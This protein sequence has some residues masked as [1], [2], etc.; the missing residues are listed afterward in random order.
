M[1]AGARQLPILVLRHLPYL[2]LALLVNQPGFLVE[3]L[4]L[5]GDNLPLFINFNGYFDVLRHTGQVLLLE[6]FLHFILEVQ[7]GHLKDPDESFQRLQLVFKIVYNLLVPHQS[8][9]I[10]FNLLVR[11]VHVNV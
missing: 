6:G 11:F 7:V 2:D 4:V 1:L 10:V 8:V 3:E 9:F 5:R